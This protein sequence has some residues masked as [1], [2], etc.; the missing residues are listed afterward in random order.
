MAACSRH[1]ELLDKEALLKMVTHQA[2]TMWVFGGC[3]IDFRYPCSHLQFASLIQNYLT[4]NRKFQPTFHH[5]SRAQPHQSG[6]TLTSMTATNKTAEKYQKLLEYYR[7]RK[8]LAS[9]TWWWRFLRRVLLTDITGD[10]ILKKAPLPHQSVNMISYLHKYDNLC[11]THL[12]TVRD[13]F[14][15]KEHLQSG[16]FDSSLSDFFWNRRY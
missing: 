5:G 10:K 8:N 4:Q 9:S 14:D 16:S 2:E 1:Q 6:I 13:V 12:E 11:Y 7:D 3:Q 15:C